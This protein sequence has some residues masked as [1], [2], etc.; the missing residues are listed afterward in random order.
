MSSERDRLNAG[1]GCLDVILSIA[2][3]A[4]TIV[5][6]NIF[7]GVE[8]CSLIEINVMVMVCVTLIIKS[9]RKITL[10]EPYL[11]TCAPSEDS[12]QPVHSHNLIRIFPGHILNSQHHENMPM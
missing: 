4:F 9:R 8:I 3:G 10:K 12:D 1:G 11:R 5:L 2:K 7:G 6:Y